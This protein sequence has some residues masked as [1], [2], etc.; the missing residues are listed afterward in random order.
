M[1]ALVIRR[2]VARY[3]AAHNLSADIAMFASVA[4]LVEWLEADEVRQER[5]RLAAGGAA[6]AQPQEDWTDGNDDDR[7][8]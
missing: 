8:R 6:N 2:A 5:E 1:S 7:T 3:A 4:S